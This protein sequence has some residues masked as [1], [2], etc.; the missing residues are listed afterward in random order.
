M[1]D[2]A[3]HS[4]AFLS[5]PALPRDPPLL[6]ESQPAALAAAIAEASR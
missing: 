4:L 6:R 1:R 3:E 5:V 2:V